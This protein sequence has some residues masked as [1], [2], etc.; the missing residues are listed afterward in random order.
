MRDIPPIPP[1]ESV[2]PVKAIDDQFYRKLPEVSDFLLVADPSVHVSVP[3]GWL[4][5]L[6][7]VRGS[8]RAI[9]AGRYR[10][11]NALG[12]A[13]IVGVQNAMRDLEI[14]YVFGGDG[15][16]L[17]VPG[18]RRTALEDALRGVKQ[19]AVSAFGLDLRAAIVP[20]AL[21]RAAGHT[22]RVARYRASPNTCLAM[23]SG[24]AFAVAEAWVKG[25]AGPQ[26]FEIASEGTTSAD[27]QGFECRWKPIQSQQ[28]SMVS[29]LI[30]ALGPDE[31]ARA[32]TYRAVLER[33]EQL[34]DPAKARP[35][36]PSGLKLLGYFD[37]Y[38][39]EARV[40]GTLAGS[41]AVRAA[42]SDA[43]FVTFA[44]RIL[45]WL[46]LSARGYDARRYERQ[47]LENTDF[48]KFDETLRMVLDLGPEELRRVTEYL[49]GMQQSGLLAYGAHES[50]SALMTCVVRSYDGDHVHFVDGA[51]GGYALAAKKLKARL[52]PKAP[53]KPL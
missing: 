17:L 16:T 48:R 1:L 30:Q 15:A 40:R 34:A 4:I 44:G 47:L 22:A 8:T 20:I 14:P 28:G 49:D 21:L 18:N 45:G 35:V 37:D 26:D 24:S 31:A 9:E 3:D 42:N 11:V 41:S 10:D 23:L 2:P 6:T 13:S 33:L 19:L 32:L 36:Q 51:D 29:L 39:T 12:V 5:A 46:G 27:F 43:R 52:K 38:S 25:D 50:P 7:D 53:A